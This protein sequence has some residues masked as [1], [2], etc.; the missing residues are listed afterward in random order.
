MAE[1]N[2]YNKNKQKKRKEN[3]GRPDST[4]E[5]NELQALSTDEARQ[6]LQILGTENAGYEADDPDMSIN[7][8]RPYFPPLEDPYSP[9]AERELQD[10]SD[11]TDP[12]FRKEVTPD[13]YLEKMV[14][15]ELAHSDQITMDN[16]SISSN[17]GIV[18]L[19]GKV[20]SL[21]E[22]GEAEEIAGAIEG[23]REVIN[24]LNW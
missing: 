17:H 22:A 15:Y 13:D 3:V 8:A 18:F 21:E 19:N 4:I 7:D 23:V 11:M 5:V 12:A 9:P 10:E 20:G 6:M 24:N 14:K 16:I 1:N 2:G